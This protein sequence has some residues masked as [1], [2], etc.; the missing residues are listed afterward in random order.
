MFLNNVGINTDPDK[1][2]LSFCMNNLVPAHVSWVDT[3][4]WVPILDLNIQER[5]GSFIL[6]KKYVLSLPNLQQC[7][8]N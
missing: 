4:H 7:P 1:S 8:K 5:G 3:C 6:T 2:Q